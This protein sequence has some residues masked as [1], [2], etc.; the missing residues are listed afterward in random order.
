MASSKKS[1]ASLEHQLVEKIL[2]GEY[3][4]DSYLPGERNLAEALGATRPTLR[5][6]LQRL[7][8]EGWV[9]I[10]HGKATRVENYLLE[11]N[12]SAL[13]T[14]ARHRQHLPK[15]FIMNLLEVRETIAPV[16]AKLAVQNLNIDLISYLLYASN[17]PDEADEFVNADWELHNLLSRQSGNPIYT[18]ILNGFEEI[19]LTL[20]SRYF[21]FEEGR[22]ASRKFYLELLYAAD[23]QNPEI[24]EIVTKNAM[25]GSIELWQTLIGRTMID[26]K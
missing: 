19:Y 13:G 10:Q 22:S 8:S 2:N 9:E 17:I 24:A 11:G 20:G 5:E 21:L 18:M 26:G 4:V 3:P 6:A 1:S 12:L 25:T 7:A 14:L 15:D 23:N 16:Y